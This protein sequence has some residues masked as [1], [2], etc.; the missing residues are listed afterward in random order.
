MMLRRISDVPAEWAT[1]T[2]AWVGLNP[3][4]ERY[5]ER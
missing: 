2:A 1:M 4:A 3:L 5:R